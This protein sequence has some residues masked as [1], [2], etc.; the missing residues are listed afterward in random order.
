[1]YK[2]QTSSYLK[3]IALAVIGLLVWFGIFL[4][5]GKILNVDNTLLYGP[6]SIVSILLI[7]YFVVFGLI[8]KTSM[9]KLLLTPIIRWDIL[10][11]LM[12]YGFGF[13]GLIFAIFTVINYEN[14]PADNE[15]LYQN[16]H[17]KQLYIAF[18]FFLGTFYSFNIFSAS[19]LTTLVT[20][21]MRYLVPPSL[22]GMTSYLVYLTNYF[23]HLAPKLIVE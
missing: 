17:I 4:G 2:R 11:L 16:A 7:V 12:K 20:T 23:V 6:V 21:I 1:M 22:L 9:S 15:C 13:G 5:V 3:Y 10:Y 18:M 14:I 19:T 8:Q